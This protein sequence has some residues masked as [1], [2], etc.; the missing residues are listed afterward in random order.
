MGRTSDRSCCKVSFP[1]IYYSYCLKTSTQQEAWTTS[2]HYQ[3]TKIYTRE[4]ATYSVS[5]NIYKCK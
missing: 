5:K 1:L 4:T 2:I 3:S